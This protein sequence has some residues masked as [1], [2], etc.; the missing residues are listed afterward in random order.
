MIK[1]Y[2]SSEKYL[3]SETG[4]VTTVKGNDGSAATIDYLCSIG[5]GKIAG[6]NR[7]RGFG[8]R[9]SCSTVSSGDDIW[10]GTAATCPIPNQTTG[11]QMT[12]V[13]TSALDTAAGT[14]CQTIDVH[15]L[16]ATGNP[17]A[18]IVTL[19]GVTP[20]N[21]VATNIRFVQSIHTE[22]VGTLG[23]VQG[24]ISI[25][26]LATP[27]TVYNI[28]SPG[29]NLS[30]NGARMV[31]FGK[32]FYMTS[33]AISASSGK[34]MSIKLRTTSTF[35]ETL[36]PGYFFLF[37][38]CTFLLNSTSNEMFEVPIK[39]PSLCIIKGTAYS[40]TAGGDCSFSYNGWIE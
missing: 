21:T 26:K 8:Q 6:H 23:T 39:F 29:G 24:T 33:V 30:L 17:Q 28:V 31:P 2:P 10:E 37:K 18:E 13:S 19:N 9:V 11:E 4:L 36:T 34:S 20:V 27:A 12:L 5:S 16:D 25:Y 38:T 14:G 15:Y 1:E 3:D 22:T 32:T 7:F 40:S 35:E